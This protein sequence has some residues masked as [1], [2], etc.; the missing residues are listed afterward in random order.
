MLHLQPPLEFGEA[1]FE[2]H[3]SQY[4]SVEQVRHSLWQGEQELAKVKDPPQYPGLQTHPIVEGCAFRALQ[5]LQVVPVVQ[6]MQSL[7]QA[8][9]APFEF[10]GLFPKN[11]SKHVHPKLSGKAF[12]SKQLKQTPASTQLPHELSQAKQFPPS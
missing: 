12:P 2:M 4:R 8:R 7:L 11:P 1:L 10:K 6:L 5:T 3:V 9:Q